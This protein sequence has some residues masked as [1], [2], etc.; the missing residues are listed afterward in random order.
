MNAE[1]Q[2]SVAAATDDI[3]SFV[4]KLNE[5]SCE[6]FKATRLLLETALISPDLDRETKLHL[7]QLV[8]M[9]TVVH[10]AKHSLNRIA[11]MQTPAEMQ[12]FMSRLTVT[13]VILEASCRK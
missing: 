10:L 4:A 12:A 3:M 6:R 11:A 8:A 5:C 9:F 2:K 13:D 1:F 7:G